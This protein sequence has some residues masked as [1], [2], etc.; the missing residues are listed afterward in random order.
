MAA[1]IRASPR[2]TGHQRLVMLCQTQRRSGGPGGE[3]ACLD[4]ELPSHVGRALLLEGGARGGRTV[5]GP[6]HRQPCAP[7]R[8]YSGW[9]VLPAR[10]RRGVPSRVRCRGSG[11]GVHGVGCGYSGGGGGRYGRCPRAPAPSREGIPGSCPSLPDGGGAAAGTRV[12]PPLPSA[13]GPTSEWGTHPTPGQP[14]GPPP[15]ALLPPPARTRSLVLGV[16]PPPP[17]PPPGV[18]TC[19][20]RPRQAR[21]D[22]R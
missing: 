14:L 12:T 11:E 10:A 5:D 9:N 1:A 6:R 18:R 13:E 20:G 8:M 15:L 21:S 7:P 22:T 2:C 16:T 4:A 17:H 3:A 19:A